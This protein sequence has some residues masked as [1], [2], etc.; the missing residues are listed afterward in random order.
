MNVNSSSTTSSVESTGP[1][2]AP[3]G[4]QASSCSISSVRETLAGSPV[5][6]VDAG[7]LRQQRVA[8]DR[9]HALADAVDHPLGDDVGDLEPHH[10]RDDRG[11]GR[12]LLDDVRGLVRHQLDVGGGLAAAEEDGVAGREGAGARSPARRPAR[13]RTR[14]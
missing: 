5:M 3:N 8:G 13:R 9:A 11:R 1:T 4:P 7:D 6:R 2:A 12:L 14:T 10:G